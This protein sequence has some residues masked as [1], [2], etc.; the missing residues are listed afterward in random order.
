MSA[1][2]ALKERVLSYCIWCLYCAAVECIAV[3]LKMFLSSLG[4]LPAHNLTPLLSYCTP[5]PASDGVTV[6]L[7]GR[8]H[9]VVVKLP[10]LLG[11]L[12]GPFA[13]FWRI[14]T[15]FRQMNELVLGVNPSLSATDRYEEFTYHHDPLQRS[16]QTHSSSPR[17]TLFS[18]HPRPE[19]ASARL[20][21]QRRDD[22]ET[23]VK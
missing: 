15:I 3:Q 14:R 2:Q 17:E 4:L 8:M 7:L 11:A 20:Q 19:P 22:D 13:L 10:P 23:S 18:V 6:V 1:T 5:G 21:A 12:S 9:P 16:S